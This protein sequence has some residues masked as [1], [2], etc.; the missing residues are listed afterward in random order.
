MRFWEVSTRG[1][2]FGIGKADE[3]PQSSPSR[4]C[5]KGRGSLGPLEISLGT[6]KGM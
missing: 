6:K 1:S 5:S 2:V 3:T 4:V